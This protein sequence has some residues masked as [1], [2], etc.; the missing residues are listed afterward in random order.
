MGKFKAN[1]SLFNYGNNYAIL[2]GHLAD[3]TII[4]G[5][6]EPLLRY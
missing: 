5:I 6:M 3:G 4:K 2:K 1:T